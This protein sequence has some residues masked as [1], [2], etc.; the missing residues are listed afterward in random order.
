MDNIIRRVMASEIKGIDPK[1]FTVEV[2]ISDQTVDRFKEVIKASAWK[3]GLGNFKEH[4][5]LLSSHNYHGLMNQ[6]GE[7][8]TIGVKDD[9]LQAKFKYYVN[10]EVP[11][12]EAAWGWV[13][14]SKGVA[15]YSVGFIRKAGYSLDEEDPPKGVDEEE[16]AQFQKAGVRYVYTDVELL[17]CSHV[18]VPANPMCLQNS[19]EQGNV[20]RSLEEQAYPMLAELEAALKDVSQYQ[21][22]LKE[23]REFFEGKLWEESD[24]EIMHRLMDPSLCSKFRSFMLK[25]TKP[26]IRGIMGKLKDSE[27][28]KLQ[29][30]RFL[31]EDGWTMEDAKAWVK[32]HPDLG[33]SIDEEEIAM[34][35]EDFEETME[36]LKAKFNVDFEAQMK[37]SLESMTE[38]LRVAAEEIAAKTLAMLDVELEKRKIEEIIGEGKDKEVET[39][40]KDTDGVLAVFNSI[41]E[42]M[43][44][45]FDVQ[46]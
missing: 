35:L 42:E 33:K 19:F 38:T 27:D 9:S 20:L 12:L 25:K 1:N 14:A 11:N 41:T 36:S 24:T 31:K 46:S 6:I 8:S 43:K 4:P 21:S 45:A 15:A 39:D 22:V 40:T 13:L 44:R 26:R 7:A 23:D 16:Y 10:E 5:V 17:E 32:A 34:K 28:W 2:V 37:I 3:K 18:L 30:L 29:S